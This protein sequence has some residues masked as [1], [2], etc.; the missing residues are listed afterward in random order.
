MP[1]R[2][3]ENLFVPVEL[4]WAYTEACRRRKFRV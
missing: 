2:L 1:L 3:V 4:D